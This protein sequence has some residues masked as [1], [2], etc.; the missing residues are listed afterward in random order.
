MWL[1]GSCNTPD[2][3]LTAY[4]RRI[5]VL[6]LGRVMEEVMTYHTFDNRV[7]VLQSDDRSYLSRQGLVPTT[8]GRWRVMVET[9]K[10]QT[11]DIPSSRPSD[12]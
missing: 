5:E 4:S 11:G 6:V 9:M 7:D 10:R 3:E 2:P 12:A 8:Y 1:Q